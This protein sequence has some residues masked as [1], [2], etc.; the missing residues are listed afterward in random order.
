MTDRPRY[1]ELVETMRW[2]AERELIFGLH[3]HVGLDSPDKAIACANA[4]RTFL[5]ELLALSVNSPFWQGVDTGLASCREVLYGLVP[6]GGLDTM[7]AYA[8]PTTRHRLRTVYCLAQHFVQLPRT[9]GGG[10]R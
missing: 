7:S 4:L 8:V 9:A 10:R 5:P 1:R 2:V 6:H 3:I